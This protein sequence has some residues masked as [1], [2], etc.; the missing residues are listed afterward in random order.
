MTPIQFLHFCDYFS[1]EEDLALYLNELEFTLPKDN[2]YQV[3]LNLSW[4]R[5]IKIFN[6]LSL[7][8]YYLPLEK[9]VFI[10]LNPSS[11]DDLL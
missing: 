1:F 9:G 2:L 4:R 7:F 5:F 6:A 8:R 10:H 3:W 11:K